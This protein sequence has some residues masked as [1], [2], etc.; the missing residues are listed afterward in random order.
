M[1]RVAFKMRL[2]EGQVE[3]YKKRHDEIWPEL[4]TLLKETGISDYSIFLD[5]PGHSLF[6]VLKVEN[7][8]DL[9]SLPSKEIMQ[10]WWDYMSDIMETNDDH[11]PVSFPL[12]ELFYMA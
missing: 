9:D 2:F 12:K 10:K 6:G 5:E 11:S 8:K 4:V 3:E 7:E 1:K